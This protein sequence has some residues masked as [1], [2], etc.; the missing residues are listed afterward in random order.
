MSESSSATVRDD[1]A[2]DEKN[3]EDDVPSLS[4]PRAS[5]HSLVRSASRL[6]RMS[7]RQMQREMAIRSQTRDEGVLTHEEDGRGVVEKTAAVDLGDGMEGVVI[8]DWAPG[9]PE[10]PQN[11]SPLRKW[12]TIIVLYYLVALTAI[13]ATSVGVM[14]PWGVPWFN[15]TYVG[16]ALSVFMYLFGIA[17]TPLVLAPMSELFGRNVIYQVTTLINAL[18]FLPQA[19]THSHSGLLAARFFQGM[20]SSVAN[21]MVGGTVADLFAARERGLVMNLLAIVIFVAQALGGVCFGWVGLYLGVQWCYGIQAILAG[22]SVFAN[23]LFLRE[24]RADVLLERR[25]LKI[26][27]ET[28]I[29]HIAPSQTQKRS[30]RQMMMVSAVRP[31]QYLFTEPIVTAISLW[32]GFAWGAVF[33]GTSSVLL[34]FGQYTDNPGLVGVSEITVAIGGVLG[35]ISNYHQEYLYQ[36]A[37]GKSPTGKAAPEVRLYWAST[38]GLLFPICMFIYAWTGQPQF[39]WMLPATF[40]SLS[41]W[42]VYVMY[43][44]VFT[45]L[46]DAYE[47]YSSSAQASQSF[48]RNLLSSTF[49]LFARA[50]Y[51]NLGYPIASTV[52]A[53]CALALAACPTLIV[54]FGAKLRARSKVA[55]AIAGDS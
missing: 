49:P 24:T 4:P 33:L 13:N 8:V 51:I 39:H 41:Y 31:L 40:L 47:T 43:S 7:T 21:S 11:W 5:L 14:A 6:S 53:S 26:S 25:A 2:V 38:A 10:D 35:F 45:Y 30:V 54:M 36:K 1:K 16:Y 29:K 32:I 42:G 22:V 15:T 18:L 27:K 12:T 9:D 3:D 23:A 44:S 34:V 48:M 37:C 46:A 50:M 20:A 52:V 17:I 19:L 28:G 55:C